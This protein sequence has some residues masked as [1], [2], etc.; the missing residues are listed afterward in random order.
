[1]HFINI[2][3]RWNKHSLE[4]CIQGWLHDNVVKD[5]IAFPGILIYFL[6]WVCNCSIFQDNE[7]PQEVTTNLIDKLCKEYTT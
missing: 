4:D 6:W 3:S 1:M 2:S 5:F 7:I